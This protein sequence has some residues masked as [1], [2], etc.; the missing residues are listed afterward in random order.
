MTAAL[1]L[2]L[3][4]S[5][6]VSMVRVS[7]GSK[8][9]RRRASIHTRQHTRRSRFN[10]MSRHLVAQ[11]P[12]LCLPPLL[13]FF[14]LVLFLPATES[15]VSSSLFRKARRFSPYPPDMTDRCRDAQ[16]GHLSWESK[17]VQ[18]GFC[19]LISFSLFF[20]IVRTHP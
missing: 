11:R 8:S 9:M 14:I 19:I 1:A 3:V 4:L 7:S 18:D 20:C 17:T 13:V 15:C 10:T 16:Y 5:D 12:R 2:A 6:P